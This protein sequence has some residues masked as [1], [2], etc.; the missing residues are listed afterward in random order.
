MMPRFEVFFV[1]KYICSLKYW[2]PTGDAPF[3]HFSKQDGFS[4]YDN[5]SSIL[6]YIHLQN[7]SLLL[8]VWIREEKPLPMTL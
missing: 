3:S 8:Y 1:V 5:I 6:K 2:V 7:N 4:I